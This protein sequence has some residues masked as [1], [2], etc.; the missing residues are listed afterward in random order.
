MCPFPGSGSFSA[1]TQEADFWCLERSYHQDTIGSCIYLYVSIQCR[2]SMTFNFYLNRTRYGT[3]VRNQGGFV[4]GDGYRIHF[5]QTLTKNEDL[6]EVF[7]TS[8]DMRTQHLKQRYG[9]SSEQAEQIIETRYNAPCD[10][11]GEIKKILCVDHDHKTGNFRGLVCHKCNNFLVAIESDVFE[12]LQA[13][14]TRAI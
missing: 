13:Y 2:S 1:V 10:I 14:L 9:M 6:N 11:C 5:Y 8:V 3:N 7:W 12:R 4:T